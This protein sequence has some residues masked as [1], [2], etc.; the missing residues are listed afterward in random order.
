MTHQGAPP[1]EE[2]RSS[3]AAISLEGKQE[4]SETKRMNL[5]G[6]L[7][8]FDNI[9]P[10]SKKSNKQQVCNFG[11][12]VMSRHGNWV[13]PAELCLEIVLTNLRTLTLS[14]APRA[15]DHLKDL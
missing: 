8:L 7:M 2:F 13:F 10:A 9:P 3:H 6:Y 5:V 11:S 12:V 4:E 15:V 14:E 1:L